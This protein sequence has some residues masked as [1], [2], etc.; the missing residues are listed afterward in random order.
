MGADMG[1]QLRAIGL[2]DLEP[3]ES[4]VICPDGS[5]IPITKS[6]VV[7][8]GYEERQQL[9]AEA[10]KIVAEAEH[11]RAEAEKLKAQGEAN[12]SVAQAEAEQYRA[13]AELLRME[14]EDGH[15]KLV[16]HNEDG[17]RKM[18]HELAMMR[19]KQRPMIIAMCIFGIGLFLAVMLW[20]ILL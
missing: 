19:V 18:N 20:G 14:C 5:V 15:Q 12:R 1:D 13:Q 11:L 16:L 3:G 9:E 7:D 2:G 6:E 4:R 8:V 17:L 10:K